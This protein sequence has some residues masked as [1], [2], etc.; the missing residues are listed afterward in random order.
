MTPEN[1]A[2]TTL[3][4]ISL[5][6]GLAVALIFL[7]VLLS[8][9]FV[10]IWFLQRRYFEAC[11]D[12]KEL[13]LFSQSPAGLPTGTIRSVLALLIV[14]L[15][16]FLVVLSF[17]QPTVRAFPETVTAVLGRILGFYFGRRA[18]G[19]GEGD[20]DGRVRELRTQRDT[21]VKE[22]ETGDANNVIS[23][24]QKGV[25]LTR[26][27]AAMLPQGMR[28]KY[29]GVAGKLEQGLEVV[30]SLSDGNPAE[31]A[32]KATALFDVF[33]AE[34]P[35]KDIV[36]RA[37]G[38]FAGVLP[39]AVPPLAVITSLVGV[40]STLIG[41]TYERWRARVLGLP[42]SPAAIPPA[43]IDANT[44]F[45]LLIQSETLK[46]AFATELERNDR[47]FMEALVKN[48]LEQGDHEAIW[49]QYP[50]RFESRQEFEV[51]V[52]EFRRAAAD[53]DLR[54]TIDAALLAGAGGY[55]KV[56]TAVQEIHKND[57]AKADLD[58]L[59]L[60]VEAINEKGGS[61]RDVFD[62]VLKEVQS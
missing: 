31:A 19:G 54:G 52:E 3:A 46:K 37:L 23:K 42:F 13:L 29:E 44:G 41:V 62:K 5:T 10:Y 48:F 18:A 55:D 38:S 8:A 7:V 15:G 50:G 26:T 30:R 39:A 6:G 27:V 40:T 32:L 59:V 33:R 36:L 20:Q 1:A 4:T 2:A 57:Q 49:K 34:N 58:A 25:A 21:A 47:P 45:T 51:A 56:I 9:I 16:F 22:K 11:K 60:A 24:V 61:P 53:I 28:E 14:T 12:Q 17:F 35:V 43:V